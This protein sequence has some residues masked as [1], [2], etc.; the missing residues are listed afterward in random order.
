MNRSRRKLYGLPKSYSQTSTTFT[1]KGMW[2]VR[3]KSELTALQL[4]A[5]HG[6]SVP[7]VLDARCTGVGTIVM[8]R[9][10]HPLLATLFTAVLKDDA[11]A[12]CGTYL[13]RVHALPVTGLNRTDL[14]ERRYAEL[15]ADGQKVMT[16]PEELL[17]VADRS[18]A[19]AVHHRESAAVVLH[20][21]YTAQNIF[22]NGAPIVF[23][24]EHACLGYAA[25]DLGCFESFLA[26]TVSD[27]GWSFTDYREACRQFEN[28][29]A[30]V[31]ALSL[32]DRLALTILRYLGHRQVAQWCRF[33]VEAAVATRGG[34]LSR[35][36]GAWWEPL[37]L[38]IEPKQ[39]RALQRM[40]SASG[41]A[42]DPDFWS[43]V[44]EVT[45]R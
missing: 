21:D 16:V 2:P 28:G 18:Y 20:G 33:M 34:E 38:T 9:I 4:A 41:Y 23:D 32:D 26:L 36:D 8:E 40:T 5:D 24:W 22:W 19:W 45:R 6:L 3:Y 44:K 31:R 11:I 39:S 10:Q 1:K 12:A 14:V 37:G 27:F 25:Y 13:G 17:A 30:A 42:L 15:R 35:D 7:R 43:E 29:Y